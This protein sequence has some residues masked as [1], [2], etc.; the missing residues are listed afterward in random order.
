MAAIDVLE[1]TV[2][3]MTMGFIGGLLVGDLPFSTEMATGSMMVMMTFSMVGL[4]FR[5][6]DLRRMIRPICAALFFTYV[7]GAGMTLLLGWPFDN[8]VWHGWVMV[9]AVPSAISV[10]PFSF[11]LGGRTEDSLVATAMVYLTALIITPAMTL[12]LIGEAAEPIGLA[13]YTLLLIFVPMVISRPLCKLEMD[14]RA[15]VAIINLAFL[16]LILGIIGSNRSS[17]FGS[18]NLVIAIALVTM[19]RTVGIGLILARALRSRPR[20]ERVGPVLF[21]TFKNNGIAATLAVAL[22][23]HVAALPAMISMV[24]EIA[25]FIALR[26]MFPPND[27][28]QA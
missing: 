23:G 20:E 11:L 14:H 1:N 2:L 9:A 10:V 25:W 19:L 7:L 27:K 28:G 21:T 15:R 16:F 4:R 18:P 3:I 6:I 17:L 13:Q 5:D 22:F 12:M 26:R 24:G 8:E